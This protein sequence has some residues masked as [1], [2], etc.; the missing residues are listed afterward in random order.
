MTD[1][2][3]PEMEAFRTYDPQF[4]AVLGSSPRL[5]R[6]AQLDAHEGPVYVA[7]VNALYFTTVPRFEN[8]GPE[9]AIKRLALDDD[10]FTLNGERETIVR[11]HANAANGMRLGPGADLL[12]CEQGTNSTP[13]PI[14][15]VDRLTGEA[16]T[17]VDNC[18]GVSFNSPNDVVVRGDVMI[19]FT[20]LSYGQLRGF[21]PQPLVAD[22]V[23]RHD[24]R[25]GA[26][27]IVA[28]D[29]DKPNGLASSPDQSMC[30][31]GDSGA[32]QQ[33]GNYHPDR[34]HTFVPSTSPT[35]AAWPTAAS[36][37]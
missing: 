17:V 32:N 12:V 5:V 26:T 4:A 14:S 16:E 10:R 25:T 1:A 9:V 28:G 6:V 13:A 34:P 27:T 35:S 15:R 21:R 7:A 31:V 23:Y 8:G 29:F 2:T 30:Y 33:P 20:A 18:S 11:V 24:P 3:I 19:W 36:L 37:P 22:H